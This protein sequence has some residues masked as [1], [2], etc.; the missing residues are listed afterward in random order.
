MRVEGSGFRVQVQG[1]GFRVQGSRFR[2]Q[3]SGFRVQVQGS[4][5]RVQGSGFRFRVQGSGFRVPAARRPRRIISSKACRAGSSARTQN[6][7]FTANPRCRNR[8]RRLRRAP[9]N[10]RRASCD[11]HRAMYNERCALK[12]ECQSNGDVKKEH[13]PGGGRGYV[14]QDGGRG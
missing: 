8:A 10:E 13:Y 11:V 7:R 6:T 4:E 9:Y 3:G 14:R 2:V 12:D 5:F 1:P